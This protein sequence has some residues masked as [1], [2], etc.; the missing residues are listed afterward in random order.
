MTSRSFLQKFT[1]VYAALVVVM[2]LF[3]VLVLYLINTGVAEPQ[4]DQQFALRLRYGVFALIPVAALAGFY[5][6]KRL[7]ASIDPSITLIEKLIKLQGF[8]LTR[9][10]FLEFPGILATI[11]AL[12]TGDNSFVLFTAIMIV[13]LLLYRPTTAR[14]AEDLRLSPE[15]AA[16]LDN[17][18]SV[19][20]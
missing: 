9:S 15:E 10:A 7:L 17:P 12:M 6:Y 2:A 4:V 16:A 13:L 20:K 5:I 14:I 11:A 8:V 1:I 19:L 18:D 3:I